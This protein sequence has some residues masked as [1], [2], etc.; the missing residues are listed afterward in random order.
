MITNNKAI[1][2]TLGYLTEYDLGFDYY[3]KVLKCV[4]TITVK[5]LNDI[6]R[7][8]FTTDGMARIK[9]GRV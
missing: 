6:C 7:K 5:E 3:D 9:V 2:S 1:A 8:Y 4:Q